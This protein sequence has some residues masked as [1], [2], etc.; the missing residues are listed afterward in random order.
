V[1][2]REGAN[3]GIW[4]NPDATYAFR[5]PATAKSRSAP[6]ERYAQVAIAPPTGSR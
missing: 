3:H 4:S 1:L 2:L 6:P 5:C